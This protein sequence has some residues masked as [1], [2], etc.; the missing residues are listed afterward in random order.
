MA[1]RLQSELMQLMMSKTTTG[2]SAFPSGEDLF[3]WTAT[4]DG[5][6]ETVYA[7]MKFKLSLKFGEDY[8]YRPPKVKFES[9][10]FHPNVSKDGHICLDIL[11]DEWSATY[12]IKAILI[13]IQSLLSDPNNESPLNPLAA[14]MWHN[15]EAYRSFLM[16]SR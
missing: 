9:P 10:C 6:P 16:I 5:A 7:G 11:K 1:K 15:K 8:P 2:I 4:I 13:S 14:Q 3:Q 12:D